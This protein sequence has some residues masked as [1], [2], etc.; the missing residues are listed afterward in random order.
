M[1]RYAVSALPVLGLVFVAACVGTPKGLAEGEVRECRKL[2]ITGSK[3]AKQ[4][5]RTTT[6]WAKFDEDEAKR[7]AEVL[8]T[9]Q[10]GA[11][12]GTFK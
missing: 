3:L 1:F 7:N 5:C 11:D 9:N 10:R 2:D 6:E 12:P 8:I 4:D